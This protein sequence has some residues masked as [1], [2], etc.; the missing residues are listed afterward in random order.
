[1]VP[2]LQALLLPGCLFALAVTVARQQTC[3]FRFALIVVGTVLLQTGR[4][5]AEL[6]DELGLVEVAT[7]LR[8]SLASVDPC[9]CFSVDGQQVFVC[10]VMAWGRRRHCC[11]RE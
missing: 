8:V 1:M 11:C 4:T 7:M 5:A 6:V 10:F 9:S 2:E 3:V